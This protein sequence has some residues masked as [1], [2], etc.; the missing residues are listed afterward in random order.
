[1]HTL[2]FARRRSYTVLGMRGSRGGVGG[3]VWWRVYTGGGEEWKGAGQSVS[4]RSEG[5]WWVGRG[6]RNIH[7]PRYAHPQLYTQGGREKRDGRWAGYDLKEVGMGGGSD[8]EWVEVSEIIQSS[9]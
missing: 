8:G 1:M 3:G 5:R 2:H 9:L 4:S 7:R 6:A